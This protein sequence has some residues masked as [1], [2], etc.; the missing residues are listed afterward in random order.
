[1][2]ER[3][4]AEQA[5][6][7]AMEKMKM[8]AQLDTDRK[9]V[10]S[11]SGSVKMKSRAFA[12]AA[13]AAVLALCIAV[14]AIVL[15]N[16]SDDSTP[17]VGSS[18]DMTLE[19]D[20]SI[21]SG[22]IKSVEQ[23]VS[24][25]QKCMLLEN[26]EYIK[27]KANRENITKEMAQSFAER[28]EKLTE[29]D[30]QCTDYI[31]KNDNS[32]QVRFVHAVLY[33][34]GEMSINYHFSDNISDE[35]KKVLYN[36]FDGGFR[37]YDAKT[38]ERLL[39]CSNKVDSDFKSN[40]GWSLYSFGDSGHRLPKS[41]R[42]KLRGEL[43]LIA[44]KNKN[45]GDNI[46]VIRSFRFFE[47]L[48]I[49]LDER[50]EL[51]QLAEKATDKQ[52][53]DSYENS[54]NITADKVTCSQHGMYMRLTVTAANDTGKSIIKKS[55]T[56][57]HGENTVRL[58]GGDQ[59][60]APQPDVNLGK[61]V[62]TVGWYTTLVGSTDNKL[63]Y[64]CY[65]PMTRSADMD[66]NFVVY[67]V[68]QDPT[69]T[70]D[71]IADG[72]G[73]NKKLGSI[74]VKYEKPMQEREFVCGDK[75]ILLSDLCLG[76][77]NVADDVTEITLKKADGSQE[78]L[79]EQDFEQ[80]CIV[81]YGDESS[82]DDFE[83]KHKSF[84]QI[85]APEDFRANFITKQVDTSKVTSI[86]YAGDEYKLNE[87]TEYKSDGEAQQAFG[88]AY[89]RQLAILQKYKSEKSTLSA[90]SVTKLCEEFDACLDTIGRAGEW[91]SHQQI[92]SVLARRTT[93]NELVLYLWTSDDFRVVG[94]ST[95]SRDCD[96]SADGKVI[97]HGKLL[98][99]DPITPPDNAGYDRY[100]V[101][102]L[103]CSGSDLSQ[104]NTNQQYNIAFIDNN[105]KIK[106]VNVGLASDTAEMPLQERMNLL[107]EMQTSVNY[108]SFK[109]IGLG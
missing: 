67:A 36:D 102:T 10:I 6:I 97:A 62:T 96:I 98:Q 21:P 95:I 89:N 56:S 64:D 88:E 13:V 8:P 7:S 47:K 63:V 90:E 24:E 65:L 91:L 61:S 40:N 100:M 26:D 23:A 70:A 29:R 66:L 9:I 25:H 31:E 59:S 76:I 41:D 46:T 2:K 18:R 104:M 74:K 108:K 107:N 75:K 73:R 33:D 38:N 20:Q 44:E 71:E 42:S 68:M 12:Y 77:S 94:G 72:I 53:R 79:T 93:A 27:L 101:L 1:M 3:K 103:D 78:K 4:N 34:D 5:Y 109:T 57:E 32:E 50:I 19:K 49:G 82:G 51:K 85:A 14:G 35:L 45:T 39:S 58:S 15:Y 80:C 16:R 69:L 54:V 105:G 11:G 52:D 99:P 86:V 30:K 83:A 92:V 48:F 84:T 55:L 43:S 28:T 87:N 81:K 60:D 106:N 37:I 22:E 17:K